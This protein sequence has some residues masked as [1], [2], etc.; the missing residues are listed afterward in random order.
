MNGPKVTQTQ[1]AFLLACRVEVNI[2]ASATVIW[3]FLTDAHDFSRWNSTVSGI[4][5]QIREGE[6]LRLHVP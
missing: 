5:G 4:E 2:R 3:G 6:R 1:R